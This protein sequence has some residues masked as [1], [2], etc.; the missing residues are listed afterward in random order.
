MLTLNRSMQIILAVSMAPSVYAHDLGVFGRVWPIQ[1]VDLKQVI[2]K[3]LSK[4]NTKAINL[5]LK[6]QAIHF[7][8]NLPPNK[9]PNSLQTKTTYIDPSIALK[10][11]IIVR[12]RMLYK[13]GTW[14]NPL[15]TVRPSKNML[16]FNA[17]D[18]KQLHFA[19]QALKAH[20]Y[21]LMLVATK[22]NPVALAK[23][24]HRPV[25]YA[26]KGIVKRFHIKAVPSLLGVGSGNNEYD[27]AVTT[28]S[29]PYSIRLV[30]QCW[31][32]CKINTVNKNNIRS[33][34]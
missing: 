31:N 24:I 12:G 5:K 15:K 27:L 30:K 20:P 26:T 18:D 23:K 9:L 29:A 4:I 6:K 17:V 3:Q 25:Y 21:R 19:L 13:K 8:E 11:D 1:E 32:G 22:G 10:K 28:F 14:V 34:T 33:T 2:A 7:G 16:F